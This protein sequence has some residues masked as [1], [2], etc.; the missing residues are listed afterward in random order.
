MKARPILFSAPMVRALLEGRKTQTRRIIDRQPPEDHARLIVEAIHP[1][2][3][4]RHGE[5]HPGPETFGVTTVDG[6]WCFRCRYGKPGDLLYVR[7]TWAPRSNGRLLIERMQRPFY[8]ATDGEGD[9]KKPNGWNWRP[10]MHM[11]RWASRLTLRITDVRVQRLQDITQ[12]E[13]VA[14]GMP[15]STG[16]FLHHVI[17]DFHKLWNSINGA[18]AWDANPWVWALSFDVIKQNVD[19]VLKEA[20]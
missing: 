14:E 11:P 5:E 1:T 8:R 2:V 6:E 18:G 3:M 4:D 20:A 15:A 13:A 10:S 16:P 9:M 19:T 12:E 7:E 17:A